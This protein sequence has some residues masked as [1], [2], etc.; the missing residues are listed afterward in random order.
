VRVF[1]TGSAGALGRVLVPGLRDGGH[2]VVTFDIA[3]NPSQDCR[4]R[5]AVASAAAGCNVAVL[6]AAIPWGRPGVS[7]DE[8]RQ[9]NCVAVWET[10]MGLW[11]AGCLRIIYVSSTAVYGLEPGMDHGFSV[12]EP[13]CIDESDQGRML[14]ERSMRINFGKGQCTTEIVS[15]GQSKIIAEHMVAWLAKT[16]SMDAIIIR[17]GPFGD[18]PHNIFGSTRTPPDLTTRA[19]LRL[20]ALQPAFSGIKVLNLALRNGMLSLT[21]AEALGLL[22]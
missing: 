15:Y 1:V 7:P 14:R 10:L 17:C 11:E 5:A 8:F 12:D 21:R 3:E 6:C 4:S 22:A 9:V 13:Y 16:Q 19:I 18:T 2:D 20:L